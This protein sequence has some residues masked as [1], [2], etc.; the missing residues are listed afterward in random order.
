VALRQFRRCNVITVANAY[1]RDMPA[2]GFLLVPR[3]EI[4]SPRRVVI[5]CLCS[6][7]THERFHQMLVL[8]MMLVFA[9]FAATVAWWDSTWH[10]AVEPTRA[11]HL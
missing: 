6:L 5:G 10:I 2:I 1:V 7:I 4:E 3:G 11:K 9:T 8:A